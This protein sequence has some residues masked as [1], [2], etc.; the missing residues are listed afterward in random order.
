MIPRLKVCAA[1]AVVAVAAYAVDP[2][3][4][5]YSFGDSA[6]GEF[7]VDT[8]V[9]S[10]DIEVCVVSTDKSALRSP[11]PMNWSLRWNVTPTGYDFVRISE[12]RYTIDE[13]YGAVRGHCSDSGLETV[14]DSV[15]VNRPLAHN[16]GAV[17]TQVAWHNGVATVSVGSTD[18]RQLFSFPASLPASPLCGVVGSNVTFETVTVESYPDLSRDLATGYDEAAIRRHAEITGDDLEGVWTYFDRATDESC[19]RIGG[20]YRL[21]IVYDDSAD[22]YLIIYLGGAVV[23]PSQWSVGMIKG[24]ITPTPFKNQYYLE[25]YDSALER[26]DVDDDAYATLENPSLL[27]LSFPL[28]KSSFRLAK[29]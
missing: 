7:T 20:R 23:N 12:S 14:E 5:R 3:V 4:T 8:S 11:R 6:S 10:V 26:I 24:R 1:L 19:A 28:Y 2:V 16:P 18:L 15:T 17:W 29:N 22:A 9:T 25:W 27:T 21:G 13:A